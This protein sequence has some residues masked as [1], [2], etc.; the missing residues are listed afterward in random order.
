MPTSTPPFLRQQRSA[1]LPGQTPCLDLLRRGR[2]DGEVRRHE[3]RPERQPP[4]DP[5]PRN[6]RWSP[7][8][9]L[10]ADSAQW[11][12]PLRPERRRG[13]R[14][15]GRRGKEAKGRGRSHLPP[16]SETTRPLGLVSAPSA[17]L[18]TAVHKAL[19]VRAGW[20]RRRW[21]PVPA[22]GGDNQGKDSP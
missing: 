18:L 3:P 10:T 7:A 19:A 11:R 1:L 15:H 2:L 22:R 9:V 13:G 5:G 17:P 14:K 6:N 21:A 12:L 16:A 8:A 4:L 20:V